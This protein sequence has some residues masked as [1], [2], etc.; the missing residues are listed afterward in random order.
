MQ[1]NN[2]YFGKFQKYRKFPALGHSLV[3]LLLFSKCFK[4]QK[5]RNNVKNNKVK[6]Q[7][8]QQIVQVA[9]FPFD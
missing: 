5:S 8:K 9:I 6:K 1:K 3:H 2:L 7:T 4:S